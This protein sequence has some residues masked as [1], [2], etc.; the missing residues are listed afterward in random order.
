MT[1]FTPLETVETF[2]NHSVH[3]IFWTHDMDNLDMEL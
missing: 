2:D 3:Q 1:H